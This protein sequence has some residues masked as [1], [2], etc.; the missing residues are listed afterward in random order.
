MSRTLLA[1]GFAALLGLTAFADEAPKK[2]CCA[3]PQQTTGETRATKLRCSLT[4][5]VV[6]KCCCVEKEGKRLCT[7]ADKTVEKCCC[8]PV[9]DAK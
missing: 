5:K 3:K 9:K 8:T 4:G 2:S 6:E 7:L 1:T